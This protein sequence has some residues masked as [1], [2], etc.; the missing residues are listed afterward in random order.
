MERFPQKH[1]PART[2]A[3]QIS[4]TTDWHLKTLHRRASAAGRPARYSL[5][6]LRHEGE[7][8]FQLRALF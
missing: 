4:L 7:S 1:R 3:I 2:G 5:A 8:L 6:L